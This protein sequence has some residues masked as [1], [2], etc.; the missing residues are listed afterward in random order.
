M[1]TI[2][3]DH[4]FQAFTHSKRRGMLYSLSFRPATVNQLASEFELSLPAIHKH[5][6]TLE[7][8]KLIHR[9][10]V[11]RTN[12]VALDRKSLADTQDWIMQFNTAWGSDTETLENYIA[13]MR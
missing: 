3:L 13:T 1:T 8:A 7:K 4:S 11:G 9:R 12:F 2:Q 5:I 6:K 10:K